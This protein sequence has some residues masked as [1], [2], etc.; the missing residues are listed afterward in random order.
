M[1]SAHNNVTKI[2]SL[3]MK[4]EVF[5]TIKLYI[6]GFP[7]NV[8]EPDCAVSAIFAEDEHLFRRFRFSNNIYL[9]VI[10]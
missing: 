5:N 8:L 10:P 3:D 6:I 9:L 7:G 4:N 1:Y 2:L